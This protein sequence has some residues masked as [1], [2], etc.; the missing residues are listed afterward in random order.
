MRSLLP[1]YNNR[2]QNSVAGE[3]L[4]NVYQQSGSLLRNVAKLGLAEA[5]APYPQTTSQPFKLGREWVFFHC[6]FEH[7]AV[8]IE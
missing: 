1:L 2:T 3:Y 7:H 8:V 4:R 6:C 5:Q